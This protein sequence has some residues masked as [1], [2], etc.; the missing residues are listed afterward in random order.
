MNY[1]LLLHSLDPLDIRIWWYH[2]VTSIASLHRLIFFS[3]LFFVILLF[4]KT[5]EYGGNGGPT[6][7]QST[8]KNR[9]KANKGYSQSQ[10]G[11][12]S[13]KGLAASSSRAGKRSPRASKVSLASG[14][15]DDDSVSS[16]SSFSSHVR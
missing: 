9:R 1:Y 7:G 13:R 12:A 5:Y 8:K 6:S 4:L 14:G 10:L 2:L 16:R 15:S 11:H 3:L